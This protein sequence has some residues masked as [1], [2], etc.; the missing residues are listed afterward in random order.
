MANTHCVSVASSLFFSSL[1]IR[2]QDGSLVDLKGLWCPVNRPR[3]KLTKVPTFVSTTGHL[4]PV[5]N[6]VLSGYSKVLVRRTDIQVTD[7][8]NTTHTF[9]L[10]YRYD[11][12]FERN[13]ATTALHGDIRWVGD[14]FVMRAGAR[15]DFVNIDGWYQRNMAEKAI[16]WY[17]NQKISKTDA[18]V[19]RFP[20]SYQQHILSFNVLAVPSA[21]PSPFLQT[22]DIFCERI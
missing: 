10:Y 19:E 2:V 3:T 13:M 5:I 21:T 11:E 17:V 15:K 12:V 8:Y 6:T 9:V 1:I 20:A 4:S 18:D 16:Q 22:Y 7:E 14:I